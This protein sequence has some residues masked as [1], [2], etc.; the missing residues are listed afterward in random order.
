MKNASKKLQIIYL[1]LAI[2][3][4]GATWYFNIQFTLQGAVLGGVTFFND[5]YAN[6][7][8]S[9]IANDII[10]VGAVFMVWSFVETRRLSM[11]YWWVYIALTFGVALAF[12]LPIF[13]LMRERRLEQIAEDSA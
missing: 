2:I 4:T 7:A 6:N 13:L 12:S 9:S 8:S 1:L 3:G 5:L 10:A 11:P